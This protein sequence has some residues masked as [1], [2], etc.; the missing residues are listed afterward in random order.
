[1]NTLSSIDYIIIC[2]FLIVSLIAGLVMTRKAAGSLDDYF[3]GGRKIPWYFLGMSGMATWFDLTGTMVITSFLYMLGPRGLY[4]EFRGGACLALAFMLA[5]TGKWHRRS[6][7]MTGAEW[8]K[9]RFGEDRL[10]NALR[11]VSSLITVVSTIGMLA[12]LVRGTS[13][14]LGIF[15][16]WSPRHL[17]FGLIMLT[18]IYTMCSGFY[19]VVLTDVIQGLIIM[20]AC[21]SVSFIGWRIVPE[22]GDLAAKAVSVTGNINW[23]DTVPQLT[24]TMPKGYE[25]YQNLF[26]FAV[27]YFVRQIFGGMTTGGEG[28][29]F[30]A[31]SD[32]ECTLQSI[33]QGATVAFR[34]P[35]MMAFAV[36]G[37]YM[38]AKELPDMGMVASATSLI[39]EYYPDV[40]AAN[41]HDVTSAIANSAASQPQELIRSLALLFGENWAAKLQLVGF[42]GTINPEQILPAVLLY[43]IPAGLRGML[44][45]AMFAAMMSTFNTSLNATSA[46]LVKDVWQVIVRPAASK[47]ELLTV[48]CVSSLLI[49]LAGYC[50]GISASSI[51][52]LWGWLMMGLGAGGLVPS[53]MRLYWHRCNTAGMFGGTLVGGIAAV[54]QRLVCP[55]MLEWKQFILMFVLSLI[56]TVAGSYLMPPTNKAT[57]DNFYRTTRPFGWWSPCRNV[58]SPEEARLARRENFRDIMTVPFALVWQV[59][60]FLLPMQLVIHQ[61]R[62]FWGTLPFFIVGAA[63]IWYYQFKA[64]S[65]DS[66]QTTDC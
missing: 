45:A 40:T 13:L 30:G 6:G 21:L 20:V 15:F 35:M 37:I 2:G 38:I 44:V 33:L 14:F 48:A 18:T 56:G 60:M 23:T 28:R 55:Q 12:Y 59:S 61:Y 49:V 11:V 46:L 50:M 9:Y 24:T 64:Q 52:D 1:M 32:R 62:A 57:L 27:C 19:G 26:W 29:Y 47:R 16:P 42:N 51:N 63:G 3:L 7:C 22:A 54:I 58:L 8:L 65:R 36:L 25:A 5:Y 66:H 31:R 17:T 34:W 39:K 43:S 41:W 10:T 53:L 4:I